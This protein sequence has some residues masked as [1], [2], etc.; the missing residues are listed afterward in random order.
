MI[1]RHVE[2]ATDTATLALFDPAVLSARLNDVCD[3]WS[4]DFSSLPEVSAG[5]ITLVSLSA[6]GVYKVRVTDEE[7][8]PA[9]RA[10]ASGVV[11]LG[12][13]VVSGH[14][15]V[16]PGEQLPAE[17]VQPSPTSQAAARFFL[18]VAPGSYEIHAYSVAW[19]VSPDWYPTPG[20]PPE[21]PVPPDVVVVMRRRD[22]EFA[23]CA[24]EPRLFADADLN[25]LFPSDD[26]RIGPVAGMVL[27]TT[28]VR[29]RDDLLLK[30]C[31][32]MG[33]RPVLTSMSGL[34]WQQRVR[35][36]VLAVNHDAKEF[37]AELLG[38]EPA[39]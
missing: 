1:E 15:F 2:F 20:Q 10:Y 9:E 39:A 21:T 29:R 3:W 25:W 7:L 23:G 27:E 37:A 31:G 34:E 18:E 19:E 8:A 22:G 6:D 32:P 17:G 36:R 4:D 33:Y 28:V 30:P 11:Q 5:K 24:G 38:S 13:E 26:R 12:L 35:L 16:G 14:V